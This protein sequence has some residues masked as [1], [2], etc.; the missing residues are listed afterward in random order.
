MTRLLYGV[1]DGV[2]N[3]VSKEI[4]GIY[5]QFKNY[6]SIGIIDDNKLLAG[7]VYSNYHEKIDGTPLSL[8]MSIASID[9]RWCNRH[10]LKALFDF[11]FIE[12][13]LKRVQT[14]CSKNE[15]DIMNFNK[16]LGFTQEGTHR[17]AW[18]MGGDAVSWGMLKSE[19][20]WIA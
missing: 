9:K 10:N 4:F 2:A 8:E 3:W 19:C 14:L 17:E 6:R 20:K 18:P 13:R 5:G 12:L 7:I 1:D 15:G 16:R 11:P